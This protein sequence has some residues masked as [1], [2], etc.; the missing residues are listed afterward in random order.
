MMVIVRTTGRKDNTNQIL[1]PN[2][3][4]STVINETFLKRRQRQRQKQKQK[5]HNR[6]LARAECV[7]FSKMSRL[8][9]AIA[10][11]VN[12]TSSAVRRSK[13]GGRNIRTK[14]AN[15]KPRRNMIRR[16]NGSKN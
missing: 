12:Y 13:A 14:S 8:T 7:I 15:E 11:T 3:C 4:K 1:P 6:P 16:S 9:A 10:L 2:E 5:R